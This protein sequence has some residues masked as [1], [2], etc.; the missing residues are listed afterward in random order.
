[1]LLDRIGGIEAGVDIGEEG[2]EVGLV[3]VERDHL[4]R[5]QTMA[6][7]V[8][9]AHRLAACGFGSGALLRVP[10]IGGDLCVAGRYTLPSVRILYAKNVQRQ[11][12]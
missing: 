12:R 11:G 7:R 4:A 10:P 9:R 3:L 5:P 6:E 8:A 1:M 2:D